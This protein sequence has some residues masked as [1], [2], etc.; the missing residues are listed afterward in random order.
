MIRM[1]NSTIHFLDLMQSQGDLGG[2]YAAALFVSSTFLFLDARIKYYQLQTE[3]T[4][5]LDNDGGD[6]AL[7]DCSI[8]PAM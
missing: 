5:E 1:H 8:Q 3:K 2:V 4:V 7:A 6:M